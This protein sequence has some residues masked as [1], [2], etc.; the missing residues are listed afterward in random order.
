MADKFDEF[1][2][3]VESDIRQEKLEKLWNRYGKVIISVV[4]GSM[5]LSGGYMLWQNHKD[6]ESKVLSE[7][8]VGAQDLIAEGKISEAIGVMQSISTSSHKRYAILATFSEA[9]LKKQQN[10]KESQAIYQSIIDNKA[11]D[12]DLRSL[13]LILLTSLKIE[14]LSADNE[15]V[16][17][18]TFLK[19]LEPLTQEQSP[20]R[21]V[22][23]EL[24]GILAFKK[25]DFTLATDI[26]L[27]LAQDT[28]VP[29]S[30]RT[31]SQLMTQTLASQATG[32]A[33]TLSSKD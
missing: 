25:K 21:Y 28:Q 32:E 8:F 29:E 10:Y 12:S 5:I 13:A 33:L 19:D 1:L 18:E 24:K 2:E 16:E 15:A 22:A 27:K 14:H 3:E 7:K 23:L 4:V 11:V 31:R 26:F 9:M 17:I 20:W 6:K 30:M